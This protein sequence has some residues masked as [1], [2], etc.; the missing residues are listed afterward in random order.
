MT[1]DRNGNF[2]EDF[3]VGMKLRH[4]TP[5]TLTEGDRS[6]YIGLTGSRAVLATAETNARQLGL[7]A[8]PL[9]DLLVFNTA[10]GKTVPDVSLNAVA[11]LGYADVRFLAPVFPGDTL[12]V[13]SDVIGLKENTSRKS[14]IVYVRSTARNQ[15]GADVLTWIRWVMVHKRDPQAPCGEAVVPPLEAVVSP[16]RLPRHDFGAAVSNITALTGVMDLWDDYEVGERIDHPGAM[17]VNDSDH[18]IATRLYQ[19]TAKAHFDAR[20]ASAGGGRRLVYGG[21]V[22]SLCKA[23]AYD[24]LENA[25]TML[26]INAGSHVNP[27]FAG[28]TL[29]CATTVIDKFDLGDNAVGGLRL[30]MIGAKNVDAT[31]IVFPDAR[32]G[33]PVHAPDVVLDLDY[34]IAIPKKSATWS[35]R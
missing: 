17:A 32:A 28:D 14:G 19:N 25:L 8:R 1:K 16:D 2:F 9:E 11:N 35:N 34:T 21:H 23:L 26:A 4:A 3:R 31:S 13:E 12:A 7:H 29:V 24:G 10:F 20:A 30:R 33:R 15:H 5:R 6:L 18:S 22:M 27:T